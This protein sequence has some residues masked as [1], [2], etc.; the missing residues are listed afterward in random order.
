MSPSKLPLSRGPC[1]LARLRGEA[2]CRRVS[3]LESAVRA[4]RVHPKR[5][6]VSVPREDVAQASRCRVDVS[7]SHPLAQTQASGLGVL[8]TRAIEALDRIVQ[9]AHAEGHSLALDLNGIS[10]V[11]P[12]AGDELRR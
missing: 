2:M 9:T 5:T 6:L 8:D 7:R 3:L 4:L 11:T 10:A 1:S 12:E